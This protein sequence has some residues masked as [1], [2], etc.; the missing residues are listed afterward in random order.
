MVTAADKEYAG[1]L[2][3]NL[4]SAGQDVPNDLMQLALQS[5]WFKSRHENSGDLMS[6][7][8][9]GLGFKP[10]ERPGFGFKTT[11]VGRVVDS[12]GQAKP[13]LPAAITTS[14]APSFSKALSRAKNMVGSS[15]SSGTGMNRV[16]MMRS[17]LQVDYSISPI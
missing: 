9:M 12:D 2:V 16:Q 14:S 17:A 6:R 5:S 11:S 10:K 7:Q 4:E 15:S 1:H 8:R 13:D 3:K